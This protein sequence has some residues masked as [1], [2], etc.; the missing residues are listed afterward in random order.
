M[1]SLKSSTRYRS[2]E[3]T[4][5]VQCVLR[6]L[7]ENVVDTV[8]VFKL[9]EPFSP[10]AP[11]MNDESYWKILESF[12]LYHEFYQYDFEDI[13]ERYRLQY[14]MI[15]TAKQIFQQAKEALNQQLT[16][17]GLDLN[18][19]K[20]YSSYG[21]I[22]VMQVSDDAKILAI[23]DLHS[24]IG[25]FCRIIIQNREFF[26]DAT[27]VLK[28]NHYIVFTGDIVDRG[29]FGLQLL[30]L[31]CQLY[32]SNPT[33]VIICRGNHEACRQYYR[34][35]LQGESPI[36]LN[37]TTKEC[38]GDEQL[39]HII[40]GHPLD[41]MEILPYASLMCRSNKEKVMF[42][43]GAIPPDFNIPENGKSFI[44]HDED[45]VLTWGDYRKADGQG[46]TVNISRGN[47]P[48]I[49]FNIA[50][51]L[52]QQIN[53]KQIVSGHQDAANYV[54]FIDLPADPLKYW[55]PERRDDNYSYT[56][57]Y[58]ESGGWSLIK[59]GI[60]DVTSNQIHVTSSSVQS[61]FSKEQLDKDAYMILSIESL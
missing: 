57:H 12:E 32:I 61:K 6:A 14:S 50:T 22:N 49:P 42:N 31:V 11:R 25:S 60:H 29:P 47:S 28:P 35:G 27:T 39:G 20:D 44:F 58:N 51:Q 36:V 26:N 23:G 9:D 40:S 52:M 16:E 55:S 24:S 43:H 3:R 34:Y 5:R 53:I 41:F 48:I 21:W 1:R 33:Q 10:P 13:P 38:S 15:D 4:W 45:F 46:V 54:C 7:P 30:A 8:E 56:N 18:Q 19:I 37:R 17:E 59:E 2:A